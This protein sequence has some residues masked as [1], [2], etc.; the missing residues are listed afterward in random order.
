MKVALVLLNW[1]GQAL[2]KQFIPTL[3]ANSAGAELWLIDNGSTDNS[4][5]YV[6][7]NF[8]QINCVALSQN[9]G[10]AEGYNRALVEIDADLY[11]L[12][13]NDIEVTP[14][15]LDPLVLHFKKHPNTVAAQPHILN[16]YDKKR[17]EYAGAAGG[18]ID[19]YGYAFCRGRIFYEIEE[20]QGQY[21]VEQP[22]FWASGACFFVRAAAFKALGGF[23]EDFVAHQE[24][25]DLC[26]RLHHQGHQIM[27]LG[28]SKVYH[29]GG[30]TL[31][32]SP[33]KTFLN[34]RNSLYMLTK[35]LPGHL[36]LPVLGTRLILDGLAGML[37]LAHLKPLH[38]WAIIKAHG[39][40]YANFLKMRNKK[41]THYVK[42]YA[43][44]KSIVFNKFILQKK[45]FTQIVG[46]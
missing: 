18:Y 37:Y 14:D 4:L 39:F 7:K 44:I 29:M 24:E 42:R 25:I 8:P 19:R 38:V 20:D 10:F 26:W 23:D 5:G 13:N 3:V 6:R 36:L 16:Y 15:W 34:F 22:V 27:A 31:A 11:G 1:N 21:D 9:Y 45:K 40:F 12:L 46:F 35:N 30:A 41:P 43:T 2:L 28:A 32:P 33:Q 17:F